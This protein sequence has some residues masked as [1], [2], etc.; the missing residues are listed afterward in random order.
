MN[1]DSMTQHQVKKKLN[2]LLHWTGQMLDCKANEEYYDCDIAAL[3]QCYDI[4][5]FLLTTK[6]ADQREAIKRLH[7]AIYEALGEYL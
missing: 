2:S 1:G 4:E 6:G 3:P 5:C 7:Q